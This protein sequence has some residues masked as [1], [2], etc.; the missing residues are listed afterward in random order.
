VNIDRNELGGVYATMY[1][2]VL[3]ECDCLTTNF[4]SNGSC[5]HS[6]AFARAFDRS[7]Y[8]LSLS[9]HVPSESC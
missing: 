3:I 4:P 1:S 7:E 2:L 6:V 9:L 8:P 5:L